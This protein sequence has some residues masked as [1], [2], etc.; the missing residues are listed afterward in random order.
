MRVYI[1]SKSKFDTLMR[2]RMIDD[3]NVESFNDCFISICNTHGAVGNKSFF[4]R[5]H[6]NVLV[7]YFDDIT[8]PAEQTA[9]VRIF[10]HKHMDQ[11]LTFI[12][13]NSG[14]SSCYVHCYAGQSRSGAIGTWIYDN[15]GNY[16]IGVFKADN[17]FIC[18][19]PYILR[20]L[21][22]KLSPYLQYS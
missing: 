9:T 1:K 11:I 22:N 6:K 8:N 21:N 13:A 17:R 4:R 15:F 3:S 16:P 12:Q 20:M 14:S 18:P 5:N 19:N 7:L 2:E 10:K